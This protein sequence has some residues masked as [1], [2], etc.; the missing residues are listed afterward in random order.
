MVMMP[1]F[2]NTCGRIFPSGMEFDGATNVSIS[3]CKS[4]CP[5]C[6]N[7]ADVSDGTFNFIGDTI[8]I[9]KA[10]NITIEKLVQFKSILESAKKENKSKE[11]I[12]D[13]ISATVPEL[14][15]LSAILPTIK[16]DLYGF[17]SFILALLQMI[18][19]SGS[20]ESINMY[21]AQQ[22]VNNY[23]ISSE[24]A[25]S[26]KT[27]SIEQLNGNNTKGYIRKDKKIGRNEKCPCNSG[28]KYKKCCGGN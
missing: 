3:G 28:K 18:I 1:A 19:G 10:P 5:V 27:S 24:V 23:Y 20:K 7:L 11:A 9:L 14:N 15:K 6:H 25:E 17:L 21:N 4:K 8:E 13:E 22:V 26:S 16:S 2:C 12:A